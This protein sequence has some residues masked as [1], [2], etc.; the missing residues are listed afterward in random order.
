MEKE[1]IEGAANNSFSKYGIEFLADGTI[2]GPKR[3][4][5]Y[6]QTPQ[7]N[8]EK[9]SASLLEEHKDWL[10]KHMGKEFS[11]LDEQDAVLSVTDK[12][13]SSIAGKTFSEFARV[14]IMSHEDF[15]HFKEKMQLLRGME[16]F[17][18]INLGGL[19]IAEDTKGDSFF[20]LA[21]HELGHNLYSDEKDKYVDELRAYYFQLLCVDQFQRE[22]KKLG[23]QISYPEAEGYYDGYAFPSDE[24]KEAYRQATL[25]FRANGT[26]VMDTPEMQNVLSLVKQ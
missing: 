25:L 22:L 12:V 13:F 2:H 10:I 19:V 20:P 5:L 3:P 18:A 8:Y 17:N 11:V 24:H 14:I 26:Q 7:F 9:P 21:F 4:S 16:D 1:P 6:S 15:S 23:L